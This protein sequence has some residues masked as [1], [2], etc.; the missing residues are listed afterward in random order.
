MVKVIYCILLIVFVLF[1]SCKKDSDKTSSSL[2]SV[3]QTV[4]VNLLKVDSANKLQEQLPVAHNAK[5][6]SADSVSVNSK[7]KKTSFT[8]SDSYKSEMPRLTKAEIMKAPVVAK[9]TMN[10]NGK[11][12]E[13]V[14]VEKDGLTYDAS[15]GIRIYIPESLKF[16][17]PILDFLYN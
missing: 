14:V 12:A 7:M 8:F 2:P 11:D 17:S 9:F 13:V 1:A 16:H 6:V 4:S 3:Q 15:D 5:V 10:V